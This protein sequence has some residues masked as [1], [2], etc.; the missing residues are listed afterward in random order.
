MEPSSVSESFH[1]ARSTILSSINSS[2]HHSSYGS[3][4]STVSTVRPTSRQPPVVSSNPPS[5][6]SQS[7]APQQNR[8]RTV[9]FD[10]QFYESIDHDETASQLTSDTA[11]APDTSDSRHTDIFL[12]AVTERKNLTEGPKLQKA[13]KSFKFERRLEW[14]EMEVVLIAK[15][16][17][18]YTMPS[19]RYGI[20]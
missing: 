11:Q 14:K 17:S 4:S 10:P 12:C 3:T 15:R 7:P 8:G 1:T 18:L 9:E 5:A 6:R 13:N 19:V 2:S 16:L 20:S